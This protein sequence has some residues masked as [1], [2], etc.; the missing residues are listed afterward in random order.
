M[1]H[2][3]GIEIIDQ[4]PDNALAMVTKVQRTDLLNALHGIRRR[5]GKICHTMHF[6]IVIIITDGAQNGRMRNF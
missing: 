4:V 3:M 5:A 2:V 1:R 6:G